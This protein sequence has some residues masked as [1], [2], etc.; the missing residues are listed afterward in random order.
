[1]ELTVPWSPQDPDKEDFAPGPPWG[2][3]CAGHALRAGSLRAIGMTK[4]LSSLVDLEKGSWVRAVV[5]QLNARLLKR[6]L[7]TDAPEQARH[8]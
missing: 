6:R 5:T 2:R 4:T 7:A 3:R 8:G 1:M